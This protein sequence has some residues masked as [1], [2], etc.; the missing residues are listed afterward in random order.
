[1]GFEAKLLYILI[2]PFITYKVRFVE[3]IKNLNKAAGY[4]SKAASDIKYIACVS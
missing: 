1:M 3:C 2:K 4:S